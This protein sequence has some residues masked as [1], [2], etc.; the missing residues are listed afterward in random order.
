VP[1]IGSAVVLCAA[2]PILVVG[3]WRLGAWV[4]AAVL[5]VVYQG[6][7]MVLQRLPLGMG[8]LASAGVAAFGRMLRAIFV[9]VILI[10]VASSDSGLGLT[11]AIVFAS[12]YTV[13]FGLSLIAFFGGEAGS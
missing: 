12:A 3:H 5:W 8:N 11:A 9:M 13:E 6:S 7:G 1:Q 10:A 2:L 4:L